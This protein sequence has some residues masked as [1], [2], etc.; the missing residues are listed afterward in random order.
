MICFAI[1]NRERAGGGVGSTRQ[2]G[3]RDDNE[4]WVETTFLRAEVACCSDI[5][6]P[7]R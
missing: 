2:C 5:T 1:G 3:R 7:L 4:R 6:S